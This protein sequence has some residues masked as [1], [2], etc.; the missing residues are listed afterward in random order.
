MLIFK[1]Q[2]SLCLYLWSEVEPHPSA[3]LGLTFL[4]PPLWCPAEP[5]GGSKNTFAE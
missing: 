4:V 1:M 2:T 3:A 5:P